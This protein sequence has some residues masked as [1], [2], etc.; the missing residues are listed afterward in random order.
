M[1]RKK[2][3]G[4]IIRTISSLFLIVL[5]AQIF[6]NLTSSSG[7]ENSQVQKSW[8]NPWTFNTLQEDGRVN[9][10]FFSFPKVIWNGSAYVDYIYLPSDF[11][12]GIGSV[13]LQTLPTH[14]IFFEPRQ[15]NE[16]IGKES[17]TL[18]RFDEVSSTW[19][20]DLPI[21]N[22]IDTFMNS[23]GIYFSRTTTLKSG[24]S[25]TEWYW[26]KP[27]SKMKILVT[28]DAITSGEYRLVLDLD[29]LYAEKMRQRA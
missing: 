5:A 7:Q 13:F 10:T 24:S 11:H 18:Q 6:P 27:G 17:W 15:K 4:S 19:K 26:L 2:N 29:G 1:N 16:S 3:A 12:A 23:S 9:S 8:E 20:E 25:L 14:T 21:T 22:K 28:L